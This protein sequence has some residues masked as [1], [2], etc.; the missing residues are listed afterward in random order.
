MNGIIAINKPPNFTSFD[1]VA[2]L[3]RILKIK[4]IGHGGTLDPMATGVLPIFIGNATKIIELIPNQNK[5]Y[6]AGFKLGIS[7]TSLDITGEVT[8]QKESKVTKSQLINCLNQ[9]I[10]N[11]NQIPPMYSAIKINGQ[12]LY[13]LARK[14][15]EV[16]RAPRPVTIYTIQ[17]LDF[18][19]SS[20]QGIIEVY[21]SKGTYIRTLISDVGDSLNVGATLTSLNRTQALGLNINQ[22]FQLQDV[23]NLKIAGKL[24]NILIPPEYMLKDLP[25]IYLND[26]T[27]CK[28]KNG[29][30]IPTPIT[31]ALHHRAYN[32]QN[33]FIGV[34]YNDATNKYLKIKQ[35]Y[36]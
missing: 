26:A 6:V 8:S 2:K 22:C 23:E 34:A 13:N 31:N 15:I 30:K 10:G 11:I 29:V 36:I 25:A 19:Q 33:K 3:R 18:N 5:R 1:V 24:N 28:L 17:L 21:S 20:Q 12:K 27:L 7:T 9:F 4:K 14:G 32:S 16:K 35:C